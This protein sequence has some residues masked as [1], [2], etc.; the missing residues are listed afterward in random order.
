[1]QNNVQI[2]EN[3][4]VED[5]GTGYSYVN[6]N[7]TVQQIPDESG[8][9]AAIIAAAQYRVENPVTKNKIIGVVIDDNYPNVNDILRKGVLNSSDPD[10]VAFNSFV[11]SAQTQCDNE[12]IQ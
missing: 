1:M 10:F 11:V 6:F 4:F 5:L 2:P 7:R 3:N 8:T 12:G 9:R